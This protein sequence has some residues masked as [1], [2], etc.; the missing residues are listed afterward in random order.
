VIMGMKTWVGLL[1]GLLVLGSSAL[2]QGTEECV[3]YTP[4]RV[5]GVGGWLLHGDLGLSLRL[6]AGES[7]GL[8]TCLLA[9]TGGGRPWVLGKSLYRL[10]DTCYLDGYFSLGAG[11]PVGG[12]LDWQLAD[13]SLGLELGLPDLPELT[14]TVEVG[15]SLIHYYH[16]GYWSCSWDWR[17]QGFS[18][19]GFQYYFIE[20]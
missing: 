19:V 3:D 15:V 2:T 10:I 5:S 14:F 4:R 12:D 6:W 16:C 13:V 1:I 9:P 20:R 17:S 7:S 18:G 11:I 8:E